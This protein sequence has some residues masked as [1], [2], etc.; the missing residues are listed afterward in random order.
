LVR[1]LQQNGQ[2]APSEELQQII[3]ADEVD[4]QPDTLAAN[5]NQ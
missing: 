4:G 2:F 5:V 1:E 3:A